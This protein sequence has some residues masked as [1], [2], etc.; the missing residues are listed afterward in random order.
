MHRFIILSVAFLNT[1][2]IVFTKRYVGLE[3]L[4]YY[5]KTKRFHTRDNMNKMEHTEIPYN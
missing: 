5:L 4:I 2:R 1:H 3:R